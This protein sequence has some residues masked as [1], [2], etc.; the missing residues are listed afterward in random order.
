MARGREGVITWPGDYLSQ[1]FWKKFPEPLYR[2]FPLTPAVVRF[3]LKQDHTTLLIKSERTKII[4]PVAITY[5]RKTTERLVL[6]CFQT[7]YGIGLNIFIF[8]EKT[9]NLVNNTSVLI[10]SLP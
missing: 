1:C 10:L 3:I 4:N 5:I 8:S 2:I 7:T 9:N 6:N